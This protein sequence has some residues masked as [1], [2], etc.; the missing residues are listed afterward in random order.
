MR[1]IMFH[2]MTYTVLMLGA[3]MCALA[4]CTGGFGTDG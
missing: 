3:A 1:A 2:P 4:R